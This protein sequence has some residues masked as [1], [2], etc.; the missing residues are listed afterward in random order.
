MTVPESLFF[1][2]RG[3]VE[4]MRA[5]GFE[6]YGVASPGEYL[7]RFAA[8][9]RV[10]VTAVEMP[11][12]ITPFKDLV[13]VAGVW[14]ALRKYRPD[15]VQAGTP[16]G[17]LLGMIAASLA[18]VPVRIYHIRGLPLMTATGSRR[19]LLW[20]SEKISCGLASHVLC[21]SHSVREV[22]VEE[23][24]CPADKIETLRFGSGN[25]VD[26]EGRFNP[27]RFS[28]DTRQS[29]RKQTGIP[30]DAVVIGF[31]GRLIKKKGIAELMEAWDRIR[32][33][34]PNV[35]LLCV[36]PFEE[37]ADAV[38]PDVR[39]RMETDPRIHLVDWVDDS[40]PYYTALDLFVFPTYYHEG[41]A[42]VPLEAGAMGLP[43]VATRLAGV[44]DSIQDGVTGTLVP[45]QDSVALTA[46]I[47]KYLDDPE[48]RR[49][50]GAAGRERVM[51]DFR[52]EL[53]WDALYK[54]YLR[55]LEKHGLPTPSR[56]N[57]ASAS[58]AAI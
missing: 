21:V 40:P 55:L 7:D 15:I 34:Y 33:D 29:I 8:R 16:K 10:D 44:L 9:D 47:R 32:D 14:R 23:G 41:F 46:A 56:A 13:A 42:N 51:R 25:G 19:H 50:H 39:K 54:T 36:G 53:I 45:P 27:N 22:V 11:R 57:G 48:M 52:P 35:H 49:R 28:P 31:I 58:P 1:F 2:L 17:G 43:V 5:R 38:D 26:G 37:R 20:W 24:L 30:E 12:Q 18:R 3:Q 4:F 6:T